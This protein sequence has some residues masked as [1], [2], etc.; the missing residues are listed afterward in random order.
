MMFFNLFL[1][2]NGKK[3]SI[4][5][6]DFVSSIAHSINMSNEDEICAICAQSEVDEACVPQ[7][8]D[9]WCELPCDGHHKFHLKCIR[10]WFQIKP[11]CPM[12]RHELTALEISE[13][14]TRSF[15]N[16]CEYG[17]IKW[18]QQLA[19]EF[20]FTKVTFTRYHQAFRLSCRNGHLEVAQWLVEAFGLTAADVCADYNAALRLSCQNGRLE[21]ARW[22]VEAFGLT[23][24]DV[25]ADDNAALRYSCARGHLGVARWLV[26]AF[27]LTAADARANDYHALRISC[28]SGHFEVARWLVEHFDLTAADACA[29]DNCA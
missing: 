19:A 4:P 16:S 11:T 1:K 10:K 22:L 20:D 18:A 13:A 28:A 7:P 29:D 27:G 14:A 21:V 24:E 25:R 17:L 6:P 8:T 26:E 3:D 12:C 2:L 15:L 9:G 23:A 5:F